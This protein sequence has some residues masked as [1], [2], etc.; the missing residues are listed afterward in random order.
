[1]DNP[2][3]YQIGELKQKV[4]NILKLDL[5]VCPIY[6]GSD[7]IDHMKSEHP[8]DYALYGSDINNILENPTYVS[9]H[10]I[11][12]DGS[13]HY[14]KIYTPS[15]DYV[16][17]VVRS[18]KGNKLFVRSLFVISKQNIHQYWTKHALRTY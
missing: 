1:L 16:K 8:N 3:I 13:I 2:K 12:D 5:N 7:N 9:K 18:S 14:I 15:N 4:I 17:V 10:P 11:D 6:I